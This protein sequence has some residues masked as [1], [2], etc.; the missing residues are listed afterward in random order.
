MARKKSGQSYE[1]VFFLKDHQVYRQ[2]LKSEFEALLDRYVGLSDMVDTEA[3][4]V[5]VVMNQQLFVQAM[6]FFL[7]YFDDEGR[8]D[9]DWN[10]KI[11][12][13]AQKGGP[14]P[15][16]GGGPIRLACRSQNPINWYHQALWDPEMQ[17]GANDI[18]VVN[19]AVKGNRLGFEIVSAPA[20]VTQYAAE[21]IPVLQKVDDYQAD[22]DNQSLAAFEDDLVAMSL[23][24]SDRRARLAGMIRTQRLRIRTLEGI[25]RDQLEQ[26]EHAHRLEL[27][28][29]K[30]D[31]QEISQSNAQ[32]QVLNEQLKKKL[33]DRNEQY[34]SLQDR[35]MEQSTLV[36][37]LQQK[38]RGNENVEKERAEAVQV[39]AELVSAKGSLAD[40]QHKLKLKEETEAELLEQV[41]WLKGQIAELRNEGSLFQRL[42]ELDV[43]FMSYHPGAGHVTIPFVDIK[44]Y[45]ANPTSYVAAKCFV[46][47]EEYKRW[48]AHYDNPVCQFTTENGSQ[49]G[50]PLTVVNVPNEFKPGIHD[51]CAVHR[52]R[53]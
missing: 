12:E 4:V 6:V 40:V 8:A 10:I 44:R 26:Q 2:M 46:K 9:P 28:R 31:L 48:L 47:E 30:N 15:D 16:L 19:Q 36:S 22:M 20:Q 17:T 33:F 35:M 41:E 49:C 50:Q 14:G 3:Q 52:K 18:S 13:L 32:L 37:E 27:Q 7:L 24:D 43:V 51:H 39:R 38:L 34:L 53:F 21:D 45:A 5:Y 25:K 11:E 1:A 29:F 23:G 42:R